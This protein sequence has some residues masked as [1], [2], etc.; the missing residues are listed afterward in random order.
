MSLQ[1][2]SHL[3]HRLN[4]LYGNANPVYFIIT[5]VRTVLHETVLSEANQVVHGT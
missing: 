1:F 4:K 2:H 5:P 3:D